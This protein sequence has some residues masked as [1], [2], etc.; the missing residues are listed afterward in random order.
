MNT[1]SIIGMS[2]GLAAALLGDWGLSL[3]FPLS[4]IALWAS[5]AAFIGSS[6][7]LFNMPHFF[8]KED[9][10]LGLLPTILTLP[11]LLLV[12]GIW[13]TRKYLSSEATYNE[14][15]PNIYVGRRP[16]AG[17]LPENVS[18]VVDLTCE[19]SEN[20]S[21][22]EGRQYVC[23]PTMDG[24]V[25]PDVDAFQT[26]MDTVVSYD[27][28][29]YIHCA[30]GHGRA[31]LMGAATLVGKGIAANTEEAYSMMKQKRP[32]IRPNRMQSS[33]LE[34]KVFAVQR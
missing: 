6:A 30:Y 26:V 4:L 34:R 15:A 22:R 7:Y 19:F 13:W 18:L 17:E 28:T 16:L 9:G 31:A 1:P 33:W 11:Y 10:T 29:I 25:P 3:T 12:R 27:G 23:V 24:S 8:G 32:G 21:I 2:F 20:R 14:V 5:F